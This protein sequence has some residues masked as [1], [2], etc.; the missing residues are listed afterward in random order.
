MRPQKNKKIL[1]I[2]CLGVSCLQAAAKTSS[3]AGVMAV[4]PDESEGMVEGECGEGMQCN[5]GA[6]VKA[7]VVHV[8]T[9]LRP[10]VTSER[11]PL[12]PRPI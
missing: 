1:F 2:L 5:L 8:A 12:S 9:V 11:G 6:K 10:S 3:T 7:T 4:E